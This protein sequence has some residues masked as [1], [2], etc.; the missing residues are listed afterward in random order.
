MPLIPTPKKQ[1]QA[2]LFEFQHSQ[3]YLHSE[4]L[5]HKRTGNTGKMTQKLR[6]LAALAEHMG[7][8]PGTYSRWLI[9]T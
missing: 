1:T 8:V 7:L 5:S 3:V 9:T 4:I 2:D 6:A